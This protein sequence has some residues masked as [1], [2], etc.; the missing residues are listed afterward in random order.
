MI[1]SIYVFS[2]YCRLCS[3]VFFHGLFKDLVRPQTTTFNDQLTLVKLCVCGE[4]Q[5]SRKVCLSQQQRGAANGEACVSC[6]RRFSFK[7]L[8]PVLIKICA[9]TCNQCRNSLEKEKKGEAGL[10]CLML[11]MCEGRSVFKVCK[12]VL[13]LV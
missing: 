10:F 5:S 11:R 7:H 9:N 6:C 3:S 4:L 8:S 13:K 1:K 2:L 12:I